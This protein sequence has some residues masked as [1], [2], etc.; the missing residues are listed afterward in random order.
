MATSEELDVIFGMLDRYITE[1][2][3]TAIV[4][5][6]ADV[7]F[8]G[9]LKSSI[10]SMQEHMVTAMLVL[11]GNIL[12]VGSFASGHIVFWDIRADTLVKKIY[13]HDDTVT[14][15]VE[16]PGGRLATGSDDGSV[17]IWGYETDYMFRFITGKD[18]NRVEAMML[19]PTGMLVV[20]F[21]DGN[22][23]LYNP[24][25]DEQTKLYNRADESIWSDNGLCVLESHENGRLFVWNVSNRECIHT[26]KTIPPLIIAN[27]ENFCYTYRR[28]SFRV[29]DCETSSFLYDLKSHDTFTAVIAVGPYLVTGMHNGLLLVWDA[30][31]GDPIY[32]L[33]GHGDM[34]RTM[35]ILS[36]GRL[37]SYS[38]DRTIR[39]WNPETFDCENIFSSS[40][41]MS[42]F[43]TSD[44]LL[45]GGGCGGSVNM[46]Y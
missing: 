20:G 29:H 19:A 21:E 10:L 36:N 30:K 41:W 46:W 43:T 32:K 9:K 38:C 17:G 1:K 8:E 16:L 25:T 18:S 35:M 4:I 7:R 33:S 13:C 34:V 14:A 39:I 6:Y 11:P 27:G 26:E 40:G 44:G 12:V 28:N 42:R 15:L 2:G 23:L 22:Y 3:V 45:I 5:D 31:N 24:E 37:A